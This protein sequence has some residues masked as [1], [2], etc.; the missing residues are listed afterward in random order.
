MSGSHLVSRKAT[1]ALCDSF[2]RDVA[3][4]FG[5]KRPTGRLKGAARGLGVRDVLKALE[6]RHD[7]ILRSSL[8]ATVRR[9]IESD[10]KRFMDALEIEAPQTARKAARTMVQ[11]FT[12]PGKGGR[13][14]RPHVTASNNDG[15]NPIGFDGSN[16]NPIGF[17]NERDCSPKKDRTLSCVGFAEKSPLPSQSEKPVQRQKRMRDIDPIE[18][19]DHIEQWTEPKPDDAKV[20]TGTTRER[21]GQVNAS[22]WSE[23]LGEFL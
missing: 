22:R 20:W 1:A 17:E 14:E 4:Q 5:L 21:D 13:S 7:S 12:S 18:P 10:P 16:V 19:V 2:Y 8:W 9:D 15:A 6:E 23:E 3:K 11:I